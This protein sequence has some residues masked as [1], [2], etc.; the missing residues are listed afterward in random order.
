[1]LNDI[2]APVKNK[3]HGMRGKERGK[4][5]NLLICWFDL[6]TLLKFGTGGVDRWRLQEEEKLEVTEPE[7]WRG[8]VPKRCGVEVCV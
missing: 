4:R 8:S 1:M 5:A 6:I 3:T 7:R 2:G